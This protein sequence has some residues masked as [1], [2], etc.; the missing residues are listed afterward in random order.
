MESEF[1]EAWSQVTRFMVENCGSLGSRL[2]RAN[3]GTFYAYAQWNSAEHRDA[4]FSGHPDE[5]E[6]AAAIMRAATIKRFP[7]VILEEIADF[8]V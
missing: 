3:D 6:E 1:T 4:A 8:L 7:E 5:I 2:H